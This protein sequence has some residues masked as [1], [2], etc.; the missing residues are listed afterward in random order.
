MRL[1]RLRPALLVFLLLL[2]LTACLGGDDDNNGTPGSGSKQSSPTSTPVTAEGV[3]SAA[4]QRWSQTNTAHFKLDVEGNAFVDNEQTVA[5]RSAEGDLKRPDSVKATAKMAVSLVTLDVSMVAIG[6]QMWITNFVTGKWEIAPADFG[7]NPAVLFS[8]TDGIGPVLTQLQSPK[9]EGDEDV[10]GHAAHVIS[11]TVAKAAIDKI[12]A[13]AIETDNAP[14]K[15]WIST[16]KADI[17]K[18]VI[19]GAATT[20]GAEE[21]TWTLL[22]TDHDKDVTIEQPQLGS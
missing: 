20:A 14:V 19:S 6:N 21:S 9:L 17:L 15:V 1:T 5:L 12:T 8:D 13:G 16:D 11:G 22:V 2:N 10:G 4:A 7:Y 3:I 18:V